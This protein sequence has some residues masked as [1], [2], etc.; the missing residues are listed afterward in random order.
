MTN[1]GI[2]VDDD[3]SPEAEHCK[4]WSR[5][6]VLGRMSPVFVEGNTYCKSFNYDSFG[7]CTGTLWMYRYIFYMETIKNID[8]S[9]YERIPEVPWSKSAVKQYHFDMYGCYNSLLNL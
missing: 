6:W 7:N 1:V 3:A 8:S 4:S 5:M 9:K 2:N